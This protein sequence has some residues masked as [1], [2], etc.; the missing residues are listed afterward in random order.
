[1]V[2]FGEVLNEHLVP[3]AI[4][5]KR[6]FRDGEKGYRD[7]VIWLSL[8]QYLKKLG[9]QR[10]KL[11]FINANSHDFFDKAAGGVSLHPQLKEDLSEHGLQVEIA[12]Y[13]SLREFIGSAVDLA[14][15]S[16]RHE[17]FE[18]EHGHE[19]EELSSR[20]AERYLQE[21]SLTDMHSFLEAGGV[22]RNLARLLR[23][24]SAEDN[25]GVE[26]PEVTSLSGLNDGSLYIGYTFNLLTVLYT[27]T[28]DLDA[29]L[30]HREEF[31]DY[32]LNTTFEDRSVTLELYRRCDF[33]ASLAYRQDRAEFISVSIDRA[34]LRRQAK[35]RWRND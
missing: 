33:E 27:V 7:S 17:Q 15:H 22:P 5:A 12:P 31:E 25:E 32:F 30:L 8:I 24:F 19:M 21:M 26:D 10:L 20:A 34:S 4:S 18:D 16:V 9:A 1:M 35:Y 14:L 2:G 3:R 11:I 29:Y 6:P 23:S 28:V 13:K